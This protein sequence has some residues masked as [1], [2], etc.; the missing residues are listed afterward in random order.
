MSATVTPPSS[1]RTSTA[2]VKVRAAENPLSETLPRRMARFNDEHSCLVHYSLPR[3][4]Q[5]GG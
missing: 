3:Q 4:E 2:A 5:P 1:T